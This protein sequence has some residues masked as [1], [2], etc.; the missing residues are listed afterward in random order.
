[1]AIVGRNTD[2]LDPWSYGRQMSSPL[3]ALSVA[4]LIIGGCT[5]AENPS[6][7]VERGTTTAVACESVYRTVTRAQDGSFTY[8]DEY[9]AEMPTGL[10]PDEVWRVSTSL[11]DPVPNSAAEPCPPDRCQPRPMPR[12]TTGGAAITDGGMV[13]TFCGWRSERYNSQQQQT[14]VEEV[15]R[16]QT[17]VFHI[18]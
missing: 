10:D 18:Q 17:A 14:S 5:A 13:Y 2:T 16:W 12:C 1:M 11:C 6:G 7:A 8:L 4:G 9:R 3:I 15:G